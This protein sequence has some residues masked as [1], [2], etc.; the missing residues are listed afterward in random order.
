MVL[1]QIFATTET[2]VSDLLNPRWWVYDGLGIQHASSGMDVSPQSAMALSA[3]YA[4]IHAIAEDTGRLPFVTFRQKNPRGREKLFEHPA[5][6]MLMYRGNKNMSAFTVRELLTAWS[7][8]WGNGYAQL[9]RK[10]GGQ[11]YEMY[12]LHPSRVEPRLT[13]DR[14]LVYVIRPCSIEGQ[15]DEIVLP[16]EEV[17]HIHGM[18]DNG[19][20]GHSVASVG[21]E[22]IGAAL[23]AQKLTGK[24]FSNGMA[25]TGVLEHPETIDEETLKRLRDQW[26][27]HYQGLDN[28]W[29]PIIL[30]EGMK[31]TQISVKPEDAQLLETRKFMVEDI[32]R[33]FRMPAH[34]VGHLEHATYSNIEHQSLEYV[35][36]TLTPWLCRW[37]QEVKRKL[38]A[39]E[40]DVEAQFDVNELL[41]GD[42]AARGAYY[43]EL[44]HV[45]SLSQNDIRDK[46]GLNPIPDGDSYFVPLNMVPT[47][48]ANRDP[49]EVQESKP[50]E[51]KVPQPAGGGK[52]QPGTGRNANDFRPLLR[53]ACE[54]IISKETKA[55]GR[56]AAKHSGDEK[57]WREWCVDWYEDHEVWVASIVHPIADSFRTEEGA[58]SFSQWH[59]RNSLDRLC[60]LDG[61]VK[62]IDSELSRWELRVPHMVDRLVEICNEYPILE[63]V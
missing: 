53:D 14:E 36:D 1:N 50:S 62:A 20:M 60:Q 49:R 9:F 46:E 7:L 61:N 17:L 51:E 48:F 6:D 11:W 63:Q 56:S 47:Q 10:P 12:P 40:P 34:K 19:Y 43:R 4:C 13:A 42:S 31:F 25:S 37:E 54:R 59:V 30:E 18:G 21:M 57:S 41:R 24:Y 8:G 55:V 44:W 58:C 27:T 29:K 5:Y 26:R 2:D 28:A 16:S 15:D 32:L 35:T 52:P 23:A 3:Y 22:S 45:G 39:N 33:W 38:F